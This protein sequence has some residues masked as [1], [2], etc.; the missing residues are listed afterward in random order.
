[1]PD[2]IALRGEMDHEQIALLKR[3]ICKG[4]TDDELALFTQ[5]CNRTG[6]D[7]FARQVFAVKRW[8]S[9]ER[10][11][12]M[13]IQVSID[14]FRLVAERSGKYAGQIGPFW[15]GPDGEWREVWLSPDPPAAAKIGI[16]RRDFSEPLWSVAT[17]DQYAQLTREG[18]LSGLWA[19]MPALML[20]KCCESLG[21]RRAFPAELSGLYSPEEMAQ[22]EPPPPPA[23][24][25]AQTVEHKPRFDRNAAVLE[26]RR[27]PVEVVDA[28]ATTRL[29]PEPPPN[30]VDIHPTSAAAANLSFPG[31]NAGT[32]GLGDPGPTTFAAE[33]IAVDDDAIRAKAAQLQADIDRFDKP[34]VVFEGSAASLAAAPVPS[35]NDWNEALL[36][37]ICIGLEEAKG[38]DDVLKLRA[39]T[40]SLVEPWKGKAML[41]IQREVDKLDS[42]GDKGASVLKTLMDEIESTTNRNEANA[43]C[44]RA[45]RLNLPPEDWRAFYAA[46]QGKLVTFKPPVAPRKKGATK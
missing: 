41:A 23:E 34:A 21:L 26:A 31:M 37:A 14:G 15:C 27:E 8:D 19:K 46:Y 43:V 24:P 35:N 20:A 45:Q 17:F 12:V 36:V 5:V 6:L 1:M 39:Y 44:S 2:E 7:P 30:F 9:R 28:V 16:L 22:A 10:R 33:G 18:K 32:D 4:A 3:T 38:L 13:A 42:G 11:E 40:I 25:P 29:A